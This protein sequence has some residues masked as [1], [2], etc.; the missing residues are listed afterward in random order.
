MHISCHPRLPPG[1]RPTAGF[2]PKPQ[3]SQHVRLHRN[4]AIS[5]R[6][7]ALIPSCPPCLL[8]R[9]SQSDWFWSSSPNGPSLSLRTISRTLDP[10][11]ATRLAQF[12][13]GVTT[14]GLHQSVSS[15]RPKLYRYPAEMADIWELLPRLHVLEV[16]W[17]YG[18]DS[19]L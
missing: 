11:V 18:L 3:D 15:Y 19:I 7:P 13:R 5:R 9:T 2:T 4:N 16:T 10:S 12:W 8:R 17:S 6:S 14:F 1:V